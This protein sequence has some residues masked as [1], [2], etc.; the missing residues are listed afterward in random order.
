MQNID[1]RN[2][3]HLRIVWLSV[4]GMQTCNLSS[5]IVPAPHSRMVCLNLN[6]SVHVFCQYLWHL[7]VKDKLFRK[8]ILYFMISFIDVDVVIYTIFICMAATAFL[9]MH[10]CTYMP[11]H[12][13][14]YMYVHTWLYMHGCGMYTCTWMYM[15]LRT[16]NGIHVWLYIH[17][18]TYMAVHVPCMCVHTYVHA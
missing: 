18:C 13:L 5:V 6:N 3:I 7:V 16:H 17:G 10:G 1:R 14:H 9:Y 12:A 4:T 8:H 2:N 11:V 15:H